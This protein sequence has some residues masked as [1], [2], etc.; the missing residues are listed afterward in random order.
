MTKQYCRY[1]E[2]SQNGNVFGFFN[3]GNQYEF[4]TKTEMLDNM[5]ALY[6]L[7]GKRKIE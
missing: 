2:Y 5:R 4:N 6:I 7:N 3:N 1:G